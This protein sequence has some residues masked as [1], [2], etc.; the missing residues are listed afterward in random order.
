MFWDITT[1]KE[2]ELDPTWSDERKWA[3]YEEQKY[4]WTP[5]YK[6]ELKSQSRQVGPLK[7]SCGFEGTTYFCST[8]VNLCNFNIIKFLIKKSECIF[9]FLSKNTFLKM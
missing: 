4:M 9:S 5:L 8:E 6:L 3:A 7:M 2:P 1:K